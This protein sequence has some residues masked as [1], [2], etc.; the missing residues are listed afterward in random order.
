M[1]NYYSET[2]SHDSD[3]SFDYLSDIED[4]VIDLRKRKHE[5]KQHADEVMNDPEPPGYDDMAPCI[6]HVGE[7]FS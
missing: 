4:E 2:E 6:E 5:S 3:K 1:A 7:H